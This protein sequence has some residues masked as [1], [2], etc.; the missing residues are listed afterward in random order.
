MNFEVNFFD[1]YNI[2]A[3][4]TMFSNIFRHIGFLF[5]IMY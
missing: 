2:P 4:S 3:Y 1:L 5:G